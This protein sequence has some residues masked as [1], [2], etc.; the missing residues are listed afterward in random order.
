[1]TETPKPTRGQQ[2]ILHLAGRAN[3]RLRGHRDAATG[4]VSYRIVE[5]SA[6]PPPRD[7]MRVHPRMVT[8]LQDAGWI[9]VAQGNKSEWEYRV[10]ESGVAAANA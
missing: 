3:R 7:V 8:Q 10:T 6:L 1:M 5:L 2:R 4:E 9:E